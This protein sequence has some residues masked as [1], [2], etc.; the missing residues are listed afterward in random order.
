M[1]PVVVGVIVVAVLFFAIWSLEGQQPATAAVPGDISVPVV[2]A[3]PRQTSPPPNAEVPRISVSETKTKM[4]RGEAILVDVRSKAAYDTS[5]PA[6]AIS[7]PEVEIDS[8]L[9][10]LPKDKE[11]VLYCT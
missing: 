4:D 11:I 3:Q 8:R 1:I 2:T 5:H 10:E 9:A 6:G 7:I